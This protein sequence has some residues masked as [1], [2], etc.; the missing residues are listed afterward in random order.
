[1]VLAMRLEPAGQMQAPV[2]AL[3]HTSSERWTS[4]FTSLCLSFPICKM[5]I[6]VPASQE[7]RS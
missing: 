2:L 5:G 4:H 3:P 6:T 7:G 1:M